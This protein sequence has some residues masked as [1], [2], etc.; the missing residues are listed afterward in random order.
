M[1]SVNC[2]FYCGVSIHAFSFGVYFVSLFKTK[3][4]HVKY[5]LL[6]NSHQNLSNILHPILQA[7]LKSKMGNTASTIELVRCKLTLF[8]NY[9]QMNEV[10]NI[11][12]F[13]PCKCFVGRK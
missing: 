3:H 6:K 12:L 4:S 7:L 2:E 9:W 5:G 13:A 1:I 8:Y 10:F 11:P